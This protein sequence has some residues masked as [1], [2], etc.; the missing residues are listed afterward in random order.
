MSL[1]RALLILVAFVL[2][3]GMIPAVIVAHGLLARALE[4]QIRESLAMAPELL[5]TRWSATVD[6]R[7]MHARDIARTPGLAEA[8]MA[9][10]SA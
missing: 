10:Y 1:K 9:Q 6:V 5:G 2:A 3:V 7:M 4:E 8:L